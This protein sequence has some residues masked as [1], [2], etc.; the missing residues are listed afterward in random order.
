[1]VDAPARTGAIAEEPSEAPVPE[2]QA[3]GRDRPPGVLPRGARRLLAT[4]VLVCTACA[5]VFGSIVALR[6]PI[7]DPVDE[8]AHFAYVQ[9]IAEHGSLPILG[10]TLI[11][12]QVL[13]IAD[14]AYPG[15]VQVPRTNLTLGDY[16]YEAFQPPLAYAV[17]VP[18]F[19]LSGNYHTKV[20]VLRLF[21]LLLLLVTA[22]LIARL[23]RLVLGDRWLVGMAPAMLVL[24]LPGVVVRYV[25]VSNLP[26][27]M[28][29]VTACVTELW[30]AVSRSA[31]TRLFTAGVLLGLGVLTDLFSVELVPVW[32]AAAA[33]VLWRR[34]GW[35][36]LAWAAGGAGAA[37]ALVAPW[38]AFNEQHYH[39]LT[40]SRIA[41]AM[42]TPIVNPHHVHYGIQT[43]ADLTFQ[44]L[45]SPVI[46]QEWT[47]QGALV[48]W[49]VTALT[50]LLIPV[51]LVLA[52][53]LGRRL[54][55]GPSWVLVVP[56]VVNVAACWA[57]TVDEQWLTMLA[58]YTY[59]TL[60]LLAVAMGVGA[61]SVYR[62][63]WP[64]VAVMVGAGAFLV[65]LWV[66]LLPQVHLG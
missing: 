11:T 44:W 62:T 22:G 59:P 49:G 21:D 48:P 2:A 50:F 35:R 27:E 13:A 40:A 45:F 30:V 24:A 6:Q 9:Q 33:L 29:L 51:A 64:H 46:P 41:K 63:V 7:W 37:L 66:A 43:A 47:L 20:V 4:V 39:A 32:L 12:E 55:T 1:M 58:R 34:H 14:K 8:G 31:P 26:L 60:P 10:K 42:Q 23:C 36:H 15:R 61:V 25:T 19:F 56:F 65:V 5:V 57:I 53:G 3:V 17:D 28:V 38:L 16:S 18:A 54:W 52:L